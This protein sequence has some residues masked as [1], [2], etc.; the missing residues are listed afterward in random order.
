MRVGG[1]LLLCLGYLLL[2]SGNP[3]L[4]V[5]ANLTAQL[6]LL[7]FAL[8]V[9]AWDFLALSSFYIACNLKVLLGL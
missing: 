2:T 4:G 6:L 7:P 3:L 5:T 8:R 1:S 9:K